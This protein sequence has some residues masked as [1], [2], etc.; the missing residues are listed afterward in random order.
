MVR[1]PSRGNSLRSLRVR[2]R[3]YIHATRSSPLSVTFSTDWIGLANV[4]AGSAASILQS[5]AW[6][7]HLVGPS[8]H[9]ANTVSSPSFRDV[10]TSTRPGIGQLRR[11]VWVDCG[12][13]Y[14][15]YS[16]A[17]GVGYDL[18]GYFVEGFRLITAA[19]GSYLRVTK[20]SHVSS[21]SIEPTI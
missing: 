1:N 16:L 4:L 17:G 19:G 9:A 15:L 8:L 3:S 18:N 11:L 21:V 10:G 12:Q 6:A 2:R 13:G 7:K 5:A 20:S 14:S